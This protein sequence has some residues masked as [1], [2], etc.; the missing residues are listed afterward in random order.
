MPD[1]TQTRPSRLLIVAIA[2]GFAMAHTQSP[3]FFSNQNQYL[4]HGLANA[5]YGHLDH[6]WLANTK[7][8]TLAFSLLVAILYKLGGLFA[9]Q[10]AFFMLLMAYFLA[11]WKLVESFGSVRLVPFAAIFTAAHAAAFRL[12]AVRVA[13]VDY[14]WYFQAG[15]AGQYVLGPG[16]QPSAFGVLLVA[17]LAAFARNRPRLAA[18]LAA[19]AAD[20]H[21]TYLLP[22]ALLTIGYA[23]GLERE[24][25]RRTALSVSALSLAVASPV[26]VYILYAFDSDGPK[27][28]HAAE[29]VL[30]TVRIP[31]H[32]QVSRWLDVVAVLQIAWIALGLFLLRRSRLFVPLFLATIGA[33]VLTVLQFRTA[34]DALALL[35]P[36]RISVVLVPVTTAAVAVKFADFDR[37]SRIAEALAGLL[38]IAQVAG[39]VAIVAVG[40]GYQMNE[41]EVPLLQFVSENSG[42]NDV[43]LIPT[44]IPPVGTGSKGVISTSFTP[45][46]RPKPGSNLIPVDL[47][48]FRL[49]TGAAIYADFKSVPYAPDEVLEW[50]RRVKQVEAWYEEEDWDRAGVREQLVKEGITHMVVPKSS[51]I[52]ATFLE[53]MYE[54]KAYA[55]YRVR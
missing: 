17:S 52:R 48:R 30:A 53:W 16:L 31:H 11:I 36:W 3:L 12:M 2:A 27:T 15:V 44:R 23:I 26:I 39:G 51:A 54:D 46:P 25:R 47:Q 21:A 32:S 33:V 7:D 4:L 41:A 42:P 45:P 5:G 55:V 28:M 40:L 14:P 6:D 18:V 50:L 29:H 22:A 9:I 43:Y 24:S 38:F 19:L 49:A 1:D 10:V 20:V 13:G 8:P 37:N 35:F 34:N